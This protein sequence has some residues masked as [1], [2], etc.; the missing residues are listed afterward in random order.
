MRIVLLTQPSLHIKH[1]YPV[2]LY[3]ASA[4]DTIFSLCPV[5]RT[6]FAILLYRARDCKNLTQLNPAKNLFPKLFRK[7][8]GKQAGGGTPFLTPLSPHFRYI[9]PYTPFNPEPGAII[10]LCAETWL[11][12]STYVFKD[13]TPLADNVARLC[14]CALQRGRM[15]VVQR[16]RALVGISAIYSM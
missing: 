11:K 16:I 4:I 1:F 15:S 8:P 5:R 7:N 10:A 12:W 6:F 13:T 3:R 2:L 9:Q 14:L